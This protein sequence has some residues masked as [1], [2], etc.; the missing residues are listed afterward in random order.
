MGGERHTLQRGRDG[1]PCTDGPL[2]NEAV[3]QAERALEEL[4]AH[5][6]AHVDDPALAPVR[7]ALE[8]AMQQLGGGDA[9]SCGRGP[10]SSASRLIESALIVLR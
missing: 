5:L 7:K 8:Q 6:A 2:A 4:A 9:P 1:M 10:W 3:D